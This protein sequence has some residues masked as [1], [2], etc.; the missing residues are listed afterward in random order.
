MGEKPFINPYTDFGF[1]RLFGEEDS[2]ELLR[3]FLNQLLPAHHQI[4]ILSFSNSEHQG[5]AKGDRKAVFDIYCRSESGERFIVE[6]QKGRMSH[7][8]DRALYYAT[9][10]IRE[11]STANWDFKLSAVYLIALLDFTYEPR[12][13]GKFR[14]DVSLKDQDGVLFCDKLHFCFLQMLLFNKQE[15]ELC[16][17]F[18]RWC[19]FFKNLAG[20]EDIPAVLRE[21]IFLSAFERAKIINM[22]L[23]EREHYM[24]SLSKY[25]EISDVIETAKEQ[26]REEGIEKGI[27]K[28]KQSTAFNLFAMGMDDDFI[29]QALKLPL[30]D[31][32]AWRQ[33]WKG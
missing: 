33:T 29:A 12:L 22:S 11:Q 4:Q 18:D 1:K 31:V 2:K 8:K 7:F 5:D 9:F 23:K 14:R 21:P 28:G 30:S 13:G 17:Q 10:S 6:M 15:H 3:D 27:E 24:E 32:R 19:Y 20:M 16:D 26:A 25:D